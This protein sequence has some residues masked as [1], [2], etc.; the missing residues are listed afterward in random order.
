[1]LISVGGKISFLDKAVADVQ[2]WLQARVMEVDIAVHQ[3]EFCYW[4]RQERKRKN[5]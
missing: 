4:G 1:M 2:E 5:K 3:D